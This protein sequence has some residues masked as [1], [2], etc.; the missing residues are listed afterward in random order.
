MGYFDIQKWQMVPVGEPIFS[1]GVVKC[2]MCNHDSTEACTM[3]NRPFHPSCNGIV[4]LINI[5]KLC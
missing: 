3:C 5:K 2:K 4:S 1:R